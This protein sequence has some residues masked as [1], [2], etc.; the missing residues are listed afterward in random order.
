MNIRRED[1]SAIRGLG[2]AD[3]EARFLYLVATHSGYFTQRQYL[4][5]TDQS[6]GWRVNRLTTRILTRRHAR[7]TAY[8]HNTYVYNLY[9][10]RIY[11]AIDKDNLRPRRRQSVEMIHT[12]LMI[13]D[14]V[15]AHPHENY[16]ETEADKIDYFTRQVGIPLSALPGRIYRGIKSAANTKRYFLD[17]FPLFLPASGNALGLPPVVTFTYCDTP[18]TS[19]FAYRTHLRHYE[20]LL[21]RLP[22]FNFVF[23]S[24]E[25]IKFD[26]AR[27]FFTQTLGADTILNA[28]RSLRY[29]PIRKL[30]DTQ[31]VVDRTRADRNFLRDGLPLFPAPKDEVAS[32]SFSEDPIRAPNSGFACPQTGTFHPYIQPESYPIFSTESSRDY[33]NRER[34]RARKRFSLSSSS[35]GEP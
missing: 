13:L 33:R 12:R 17:R 1:L 5:F 10:R 2:Y 24:A 15:L 26:R 23:A 19:L 29:F 35:A 4:T 16:V 14:F 21:R 22:D 6:H 3:T 32:L 11:D 31:H 18:G 9:S 25:P 8:A 34:D 7:S 28:H 30:W 27:A 20:S